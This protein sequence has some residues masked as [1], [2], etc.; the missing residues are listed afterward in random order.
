M[1]NGVPFSVAHADLV[2]LSDEFHTDSAG[3]PAAHT[4]TRKEVHIEPMSTFVI[5]VTFCKI[6]VFIHL[7]RG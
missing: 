5:L 3:C 2:K 1:N 4:G 7:I 6:S